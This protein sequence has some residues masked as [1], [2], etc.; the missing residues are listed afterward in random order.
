[1][2]DFSQK[3]SLFFVFTVMRTKPDVTINYME[4]QIFINIHQYRAAAMYSETEVRVF[5]ELLKQLTTVQYVI[6]EKQ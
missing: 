6:T 1:M 3:M 5:P 2:H 4:S